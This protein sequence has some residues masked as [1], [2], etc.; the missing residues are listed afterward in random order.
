MKN[1]E[2][3]RLFT[4]FD[5]EGDRLLRYVHAKARRLSRMDAEDIVSEVM[6]S[7][8]GRV[9]QGGPVENIAAYAY[10]SIRNKIADYGRTESRTVS[11]DGFADEDRAFSLREMLS[12]STQDIASRV[13]HMELLRVLTACMDKL[14]GKQRAV[15]IATEMHGRSFRELSRAW[16]EPVGTLLSRKSRAVKTIRDMLKTDGLLTK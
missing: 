5:A 12:D 3:S 15:L 1:D 8:M 14:D 6:L 9:D 11:L 16:H 4:F 10:R 13:E 7:L 2:R